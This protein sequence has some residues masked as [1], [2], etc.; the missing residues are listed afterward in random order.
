MS[1]NIWGVYEYYV[2]GPLGSVCIIEGRWGHRDS[3]K[4]RHLYTSSRSKRGSSSMVG[5]THVAKA[6]LPFEPWKHAISVCV[7]RQVEYVCVY[8]IY[9]YT[10]RE[11]ERE[12]DGERARGREERAR[13]ET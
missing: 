5:E 2:L 3:L 11:R 1:V 9:V 4:P 8:M 10:Q 12:R 7:C 6:R 13:R